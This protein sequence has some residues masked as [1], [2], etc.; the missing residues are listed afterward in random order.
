MEV[1]ALAKMVAPEEEGLRPLQDAVMAAPALRDR[2]ITAETGIA[3]ITQEVVVVEVYHLEAMEVAGK[4]ATEEMAWTMAPPISAPPPG[5]QTPD[6]LE[7]EEEEALLILARP[8]PAVMAEV[9][10][11]TP[12]VIMV[13]MLRLIPVAAAAALLLV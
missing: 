4:L 7:E 1:A 6:S 5:C 11:V 3:A 12:R 8:D 2:V 13:T 9:A 10:P